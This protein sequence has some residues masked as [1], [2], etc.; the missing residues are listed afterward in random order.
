MSQGKSLLAPLADADALSLMRP[1]VAVYNSPDSPFSVIPAQFHQPAEVQT[2]YDVFKAKYEAAH[3]N[4]PPQTTQDRKAQRKEFNETMGCF[5]DLVELASRKDP[6]LPARFSLHTL[7]SLKTKPSSKLSETSSPSLQLQAVDKILNTVQCKV[8]GGA[9]KGI[10]VHL[11]YDDPSNESNW[12]RFDSF[13]HAKFQMAGLISGKR[14][15]LRGR[16]VLA[17]GKKGPWSEMVS[18]MVP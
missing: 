6:S 10:E 17:K 5:L 9:K 3:P 15:Y 7:S 2:A 11:T 14:A 18:I 8:P 1:A 12:Q 4:E 16:Y 13:F